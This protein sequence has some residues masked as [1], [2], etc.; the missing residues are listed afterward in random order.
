MVDSYVSLGVRGSGGLAR[1]M[2]MHYG[3]TEAI[4]SGKRQE[5]FSGR[6]LYL[7]VCPV[8]GELVGEPRVHGEDV[9]LLCF[10]GIGVDIHPSV[11]MYVI[12]VFYE[13]FEATGFTAAKC[14]TK[15]RVIWK[16]VSLD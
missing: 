8:V 10:V 1:T 16:G 5:I 14:I 4:P 12:S 3:K 2:S 13:G 6:I 7:F 9:V 15:N 11:C